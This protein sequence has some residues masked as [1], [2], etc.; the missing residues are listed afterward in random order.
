MA[1]T[2][3]KAKKK[4]PDLAGLVPAPTGGRATTE[5]Q[6]ERVRASIPT[7]SVTVPFVPAP[8]KYKQKTLNMSFDQGT[9]EALR[10]LTEGL[11]LLQAKTSNGRVVCDG[12]DALR[13][14]L[15]QIGKAARA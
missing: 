11:E 8:L 1:T 7:V 5:Q 14:V 9:S 12:A 4:G 3:Q 6:A 13:W 15:E 2:E 10:A